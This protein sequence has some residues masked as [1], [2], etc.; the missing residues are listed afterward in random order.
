[1][2]LELVYTS[3]PMGLLPGR[4]GFSTV[5]MTKG[6]NPLLVNTLEGMVAY[7][8]L[9]EHYDAKAA[10]NPPS[11]FHSRISSGRENYDVLGRVSACGL[12]YTKRS[13]KIGHFILFPES[14]KSPVGPSGV[15]SDSQL[16]ITEWEGAPRYYPAPRVVNFQAPASFRASAWESVT[17][18]AGWGAWLAESY[19]SRKDVPCFVFYD[20]LRQSDMLSL[21]RES[22]L[23]LPK[24]MRW[25]V[26][27]NTYLTSLP[28]G[29][30]CNWRFC[31]PTPEILG[32][33]G[34][35]P[36]A[37][38]LDLRQPL[39]TA[40][41][42]PLADCA[43]NGMDPYPERKSFSVPNPPPQS[44]DLKSRSNDGM[45]LGALLHQ[46]QADAAA[47]RSA[48]IRVNKPPVGMGPY[49]PMS[50][51]PFQ[52]T[53]NQPP[54]VEKK[55]NPLLFLVI[56]L[57]VVLGLAGAGI[58]FMLK[59]DSSKTMEALNN[60]KTAA[61]QVQKN[62]EK[63]KKDFETAFTGLEEAQKK[64]EGIIW[65]MKGALEKA[66]EAKKAEE[67]LKAEEEKKKQ[68]STAKQAGNGANDPLQEEVRK[69]Y[70]EWQRL[71][72][73]VADRANREKAYNEKKTAKE[74]AQNELKNANDNLSNAE[75]ERKSASKKDRA[76][77]EKGEMTA[78]KDR[79]AKQNAYK[80][81][82]DAFKNAEKDWKEVEGLSEKNVEEADKKWQAAK[83]A[84]DDSREKSK[85]K[86]PTPDLNQGTELDKAIRA[87]EE[88]R[89]ELDKA[90][91]EMA[92][93]EKQKHKDVPGQVDRIVG[94]LKKA[95]KGIPVNMQGLGRKQME[96]VGNRLN[97]ASKKAKEAK[98]ELDGRAR[99]INGA[100]VK[101]DDAM[102][103]SKQALEELR[104]QTNLITEKLEPGK[105]KKQSP[106]KPIMEGPSQEKQPPSDSGKM[107]SLD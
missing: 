84:Y 101:L 74:T 8:P 48:S 23:F 78:K 50:T 14:E 75:K 44:A 55:K 31:V 30:K 77:K 6:M 37:N 17:G 24:E 76:K 26:T 51:P 3:V 95:L 64:A 15:L 107:K 32:A 35:G 19:M 80:S 12:D 100:K 27:W 82:R 33:I 102:S 106:P 105:P 93:P 104:N 79:D 97:A 11:F 86:V 103:E 90:V 45:S 73:L 10:F 88:K 13:N 66:G 62:L 52:G 56:A 38:V 87:A 40:G 83:K 53:M 63:S 28:A 98:D 85:A 92:I 96:D 1:M 2:A 49:A 21:V 54:M 43:R 7:T 69:C 67:R 71:K 94:D 47:A 81:A 39:G 58:G 60:A 34:C 99:S 68:T 4:T 70:T 20:P 89:N 57:L 36:N 16:F 5:A 25:E 59:N 65:D 29:A 61:V 18:D 41:R 46:S 72:K 22:L 42:G 9:F 91:K